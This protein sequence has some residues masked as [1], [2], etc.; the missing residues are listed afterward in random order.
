MQ[1]VAAGESQVYHASFE[2]DELACFQAPVMELVW[3]T[4]QPGVKIDDV[5]RLVASSADNANEG[6]KEGKH[7]H[8]DGAEHECFGAT[9]GRV[10]EKEML[11]YIAGWSSIEVRE[12]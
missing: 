2:G 6:V 1:P 10:V 3:I 7:L 12:D 8:M 11:V 4:P 5:A 9:W